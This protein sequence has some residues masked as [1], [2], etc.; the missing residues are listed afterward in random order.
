[1]RW[2]HT[3]VPPAP[4]LRPV[5]NGK[6]AADTSSPVTAAST[7]AR[8]RAPIPITQVA[9]LS[10]AQ[11]DRPSS[12]RCGGQPAEVGVDR[13]RARDDAEALL[14]EPR[15][16]EV[17]PT[18]RRARSGTANR[19]RSPPRAS[20]CASPDTRSSSAAAPGPST[21]ILPG[22]MSGRSSRR[23]RAA[24]PT[25]PRARACTAARP[26][27]RRAAPPPPAATAARA[28][29]SRRAPSRA[30][31]RR[32]RPRP[33]SARAARSSGAAGRGR[34]CRAG[35]A[36]GSS[37]DRPRA[38]SRR[39]TAGRGGPR[40]SATAGRPAGRARSPVVTSLRHGPCRARPRRRSRSASES[41]ARRRSPARPVR[42]TSGLPSGVIASGWQTSLTTPASARERKRRAAPCMSGSKR[43]SSAGMVCPLCS[44]GT[45]STQRAT[46]LGS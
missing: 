40:R 9:S 5:A 25:P 36:A 33:A 26:S 44:H 31:R 24:P 35:S 8:V 28:G 46:G 30:W 19:R 38:R 18:M 37:S 13:A 32:P 2:A 3:C 6:A 41:P 21:A 17:G 14:A 27:R 7:V 20:T 23:A 16:R 42:P 34:R 22:A 4:R 45:P 29:S 15:H 1:M 12:S 10:V 43:A 39:R 11:V